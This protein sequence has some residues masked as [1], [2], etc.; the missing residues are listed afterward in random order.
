M[1]NDDDLWTFALACY[2]APGVEKACLDLQAMGADVCLLL[3]GAWLEIRGVTCNEQRLRQLKQ[4]SRDWQQEVV[5]PLRSLRLCWGEQTANDAALANLRERIKTLELD[6]ERIQ[7][8]RL[9]QA[10]GGWPAGKGPG[11]W[12][13]RLCAGLQGEP[14]A[15]LQLL[16]R[17]AQAQLEA[18]GEG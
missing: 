1:N 15:S 14:R 8:D 16:R 3:S 9:Q 18:P 10:S 7:L 5:A 4:L 12:L 6:A 11:Q 2:A 13:E 17:A